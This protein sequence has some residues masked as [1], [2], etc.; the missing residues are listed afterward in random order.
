MVTG[1]NIDTAL[2]IAQE[3]YI[4]HDKTEAILGDKFMEKIGGVV[5]ENCFP[6]N[7]YSSRYEEMVKSCEEKKIKKDYKSLMKGLNYNCECYRTTKEA[8]M[9][10]KAKLKEDVLRDDPE[11]YADIVRDTEQKELFEKE[12]D[13]KA[14][15]I[16]EEKNIKIRKDIIANIDKFNKLIEKKRV[17]ARSHPTHKYALVTGLKEN[18]HVVAVTG[19]GTNDAPAL[20][21]ADV[22]FAMGKGTDI[23]KEAS[24]IIIVDDNFSSIVNAV[25]WG[26]N[27]YDN[28]R[29]FLQF[30]L[31]VNIVACTLVFIGVCA[32]S[33]SPLSAVQMLWLNMIMD[34]LGSLALATEDPTEELLYREPY[35][36]DELIVNKKMFKH[37]IGQSIVQLTVLIILL[38]A[39]TQLIYE[40][41]PAMVNY[42][43]QFSRCFNYDLIPHSPILYHQGALDDKR[44]FLITGFESL[45]A[46]SDTNTYLNLPGCNET[47]NG[48]NTLM[49]A[50]H[51]YLSDVFS[52]T[53]F[54][55][56]FNTFVFMQ[57]FNEVNCRILDDRFNIFYRI[58]KNYWFLSIW[59]IEVVMQ[60]C[61]IQFMGSIFHCSKNVIYINIR[62]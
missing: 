6:K 60:V 52:T 34:S 13:E 33:E 45:F 36:R 55:I 51:Y 54:T 59:A 31:T 11:K 40:T 35:K 20:S 3:C 28:I 8:V 5:C 43:Y 39:A 27:I 53:H 24:D 9:K 47:F 12:L 26:R 2:A 29:R 44:M 58:T 32:G 19:D 10:I 56:V 42:S 18:D 22:G 23:A 50:Y 4:A 30:Q 57:L 62:D 7:E 48:Q 38:F 25:K 41:E 16:I 14:E 15:A 1:D 46:N 37:I 17:I 49:G 61:I 21:K